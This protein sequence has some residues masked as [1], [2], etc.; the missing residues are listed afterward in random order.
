M[1][2]VGGH[3]RERAR[4]SRREGGSKRKT[5]ARKATRAEGTK[6]GKVAGAEITAR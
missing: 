4:D 6:A 1:F 2:D 3:E 5:M